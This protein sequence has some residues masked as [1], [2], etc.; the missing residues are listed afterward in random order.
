MSQIGIKIKV[1]FEQALFISFDKPDSIVFDFADLRLFTSEDG[2]MMD[3]ASSKVVRSL[4][5]QV[6]GEAQAT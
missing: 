4:M 3:A 5:R 6:P 2:I 1:N